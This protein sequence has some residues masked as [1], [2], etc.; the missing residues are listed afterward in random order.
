M[1]TLRLANGE[2]CQF[3]SALRLVLICLA[4]AISSVAMATPVERWTAL[5]TNAMAITGD[6]KLSNQRI[7]FSNGKALDLL[8]E[9]PAVGSAPFT[10]NGQ[11]ISATVYRVT[12]PMRV[13]LKNGNGLCGR[14]QRARPVTFVAVWKP[15]PMRGDVAPRALAVFSGNNAPASTSDPATCGVYYYEA[16]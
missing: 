3:R 2:L 6:V 1:F 16:E 10:D 13:K 12:K 11:P 14:S 15:E 9:V 8:M 5:S 7:T 4:L